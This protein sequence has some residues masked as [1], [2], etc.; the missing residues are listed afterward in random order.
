MRVIPLGSVQLLFVHRHHF[1]TMVDV[2]A[3][4]TIT[5]GPTE[6]EAGSPVSLSLRDADSPGGPETISQ[7]ETW[8][9]ESRIVDLGVAV[10]ADRW[11][12]T[13]K[14]PGS[15]VVLELPAIA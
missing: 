10:L 12:L 8:G 3:M 4:D 9:Q 11:F 14:G 15:E 5:F 2:I 1:A 7:L 6:V 13:V